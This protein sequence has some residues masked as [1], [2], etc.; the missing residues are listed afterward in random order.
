MRRLQEALIDVNERGAQHLKL[1]KRFVEA[2]LGAMEHRQTEH[3]GLKAKFDN[4]KVR[5]SFHRS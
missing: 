2:I 1:E 3:I 5:I 4:V